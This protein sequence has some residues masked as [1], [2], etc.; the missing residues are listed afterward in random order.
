MIVAGFDPAR[1]LLVPE[2]MDTERVEPADLARCLADL[3]R[4]SGLT[5]GYRPTLAWFARVTAALPA[6]S[7][8]SVL[9]IACGGGDMLRAIWAKARGKG[10]RVRLLGVD[11]NPD[12]IAI[13]RGRTPEEA[14]I[15]YI[16]GDALAL[17]CDADLI[18]NALFLHHLDTQ[19]AVHLLRWMAGRARRGWLVNDLHRHALSYWG[20]RL[21]T[22]LLGMHR[23]V[24]ADGPTSVARGWSAAELRALAAQ[25]GLSDAVLRWHLP[26]RWSLEGETLRA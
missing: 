8:L 17:S 11:T 25:A 3:E 21:G 2:R 14:P 12:T 1:R 18:I 16:V 26:F 13:A 6:G 4:L 19:D 5:L 23:F 15:D 10:W 24:R 7:P 20:L 9:D 22:P